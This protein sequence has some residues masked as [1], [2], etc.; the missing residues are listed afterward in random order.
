LLVIPSVKLSDLGLFDGE[1]FKFIDVF[2]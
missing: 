1:N 2:E